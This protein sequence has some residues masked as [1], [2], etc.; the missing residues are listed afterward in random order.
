MTPIEITLTLQGLL[1]LSFTLI[2]FWLLGYLMGKD[3]EAR[4]HGRFLE[5]LAEALHQT[6]PLVPSTPPTK[7]EWLAEVQSTKP[8]TK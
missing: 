6:T 8:D 3:K 4:D 2:V 1:I 7:E 5:T